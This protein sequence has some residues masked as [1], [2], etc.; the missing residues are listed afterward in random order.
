MLTD[1][2]MLLRRKKIYMYFF[3][4]IN[5]GQRFIF[6]LLEFKEPNSS[7]EGSKKNKQTKTPRNPHYHHMRTDRKRLSGQAHNCE[8]SFTCVHVTHMDARMRIICNICTAVP[9]NDTFF[10]CKESVVENACVSIHADSGTPPR[11]C[12]ARAPAPLQGSIPRS[13]MTSCLP[14]QKAPSVRFSTP[15]HPFLPKCHLWVQLWAG[16]SNRFHPNSFKKFVSGLR[17]TQLSMWLKMVLACCTSHPLL[18]FSPSRKSIFQLQGLFTLAYSMMGTPSFKC[19]SQ[20][21]ASIH[22]FC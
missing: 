5:D 15:A 9:C 12:S 22:F 10:H 8:E 17:A 7:N 2:C 11:C 14:P 19:A 18:C 1:L 13:L 16:S 21:L 20:S 4:Y 3:L 6:F